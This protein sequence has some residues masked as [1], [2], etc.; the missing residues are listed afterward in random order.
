MVAPRFV[1]N[2]AH[3]AAVFGVRKTADGSLKRL[4]K[5]LGPLGVD[6]R[7]ESYKWSVVQALLSRGDRRVADVLELVRAYGDSLGS[8]KRAFKELKGRLPPLEW[9]AHADWGVGE[10]LPWGHLTTAVSEEAIV[11]HR[12]EA[13]SLFRGE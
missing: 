5:R 12:D 10:V 6:F 3:A 8:F 4:A 11:R 13:V 9:Y 2:G 7:P 1:P